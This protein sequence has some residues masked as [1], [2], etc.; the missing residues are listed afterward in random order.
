MTALRE[1]WLGDAAV[2]WTDALLFLLLG[3]VA[4]FALYA[5]RHEHLR[6]PWRQVARHRLGMASAVVLAAYLMIALLD[7]L[8]FHPRLGDDAAPAR[9]SP[10]IVSLFDAFAAPLRRQTEQTYSAPF[11]TRSFIRT[12]ID[13]ADGSQRRE[14]PPLRYG[15]AHLP[16]RDARIPDIARTAWRALIDAAVLWMVL[17]SLVIAARARQVRLPFLTALRRVL[18]GQTDVPWRPILLTGFAVCALVFLGARLG[19]KY[20]VFGTDKVGQD[21]FY[22]ALKSIRTGLLIGTLTTLIMLPFAIALGVMAGY[23]RG[24]VDDIIQYL[25]TTLNSIPGVL[26]IAASVLMLQ[27]YMANHAAEF[28]SIEQRSDLRLLFLCIILGV[29]SWT[30][31]C[32]LLRGEALK[33]RE[34]DYVQAARALGT[35]HAAILTRHIVPNVM[36]IVMIAVVLD[37]SGLVLAEAVLS[38]ISIGVDPSM[39][40]WGNM[41]NSARLELAREPVVWW[42]LA[43]AFLFMFAL[44]LAANLFADTVR[45]AFD[46]RVRKSR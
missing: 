28:K 12:T 41:I 26:L 40:S 16:E 19:V 42:S 43:A 11:A 5:R 45:D 14:Y 21:V 31:L 2:L 23:F 36:H 17:A 10:A 37:F 25:Y 20:H 1:W 7:S 33:L 3:V 29:M 39:Q 44:V 4:A 15:G 30:G 35:S 24:I 34:A 27:V 32:R 38:Y 46:P 18:A 6:A 8:H 13:T 9:Y 22:L